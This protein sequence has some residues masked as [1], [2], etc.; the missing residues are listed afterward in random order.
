MSDERN[1]KDQADA[2]LTGKRGKKAGQ[3]KRKKDRKRSAKQSRQ[4]D[5]RN[6]LSMFSSMDD[7]DGMTDAVAQTLVTMMGSIPSFAVGESMITASNAQ[8]Q[9]LQNAVAQQQ[10]TNLIGMVATYG[11]V[12]NLLDMRPDLEFEDPDDSD[13]E[14]LYPPAGSGR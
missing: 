5:L 2:S 9:M 12:A 3:K 7:R 4:P 14:P 8:G 6:L 11:C 1:R 10:K 13:L